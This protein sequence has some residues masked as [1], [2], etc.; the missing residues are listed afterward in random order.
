MCRYVQA[1]QCNDKRGQEDLLKALFSDQLGLDSFNSYHK[2]SY[3]KNFYHMVNFT[4]QWEAHYKP[5]AMEVILSKHYY[6]TNYIT[7]YRETF[8]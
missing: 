7:A 3:C 6:F 8:F 5:A 4:I 1:M 2:S